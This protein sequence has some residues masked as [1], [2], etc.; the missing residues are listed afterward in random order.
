MQVQ[1]I[2]GNGEGEPVANLDPQQ[3]FGFRTEAK[4]IPGIVIGVGM[5]LDGN[6]FG[7]ESS[8]YLR[9]QYTSDCSVA[10][11]DNSRRLGH[12]T[13]RLGTQLLLDSQFHGMQG[14]M[15]SISGQRFD[16]RNLSRWSRSQPLAS[17]LR[18]VTG[19]RLDP[20]Q[21]FAEPEAGESENTMRRTTAAASVR[22]RISERYFVG[23]D[24]SARTVTSSDVAIFTK[25]LAFTGTLCTQ[26]E[27]TPRKSLKESL[28]VLGGGIL[29]SPGLQMAVEYVHRAYDQKYSQFNYPGPKDGVLAESE[30]M[31]VRVSYGIK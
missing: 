21:V 19:C 16:S 3:Y 18:A 20:G 28:W 14:V 12:S 15:L 5:S 9:K 11:P 17:E 24:Y 29:L 1:F 8:A 27:G 6:D 25:C 4:I 10:P 7:S 26:P 2:G 30:M 23:G 31:G 22:Y 13:Q